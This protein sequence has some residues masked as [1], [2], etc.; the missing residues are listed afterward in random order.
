MWYESDIDRM[1]KRTRHRPLPQGRIS[2]NHALFLGVSLTIAPIV[3]M[4]IIVNWLAA[5]LLG[6]ASIIYVGVYTI[7]LKRR[8]PQ[9]IV[10]GGASGALPPLIGWV[11]VTGSIDIPAVLLFLII[12][13]WTPP[14]FWALALI[15]RQD[16]ELAGIPMMPVIVG[17]QKTRLYILF[18]TLLLWPAA[19]AP[20]F[21]GV[22]GMLYAVS[23]VVLSTAF[24]VYSAY[25]YLN[26][27]K[28]APQALFFFFYSL[29]VPAVLYPDRKRIFIHLNPFDSLKKIVRNDKKT[30]HPS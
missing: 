26:Q 17:E 16:Y 21:F 5:A 11:C 29:P 2:S 15:C 14:H 20:I 6:L 7:W 18:Y 19:V 9:N 8:S 3:V 12:F 4:G 30:I 27:A 25:V 13:L 1:M 23:A 22:G 24:V 28:K 10:I